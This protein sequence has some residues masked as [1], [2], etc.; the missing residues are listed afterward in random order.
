MTEQ[1]F[2]YMRKLFIHFWMYMY[3]F[4]ESTRHVMAYKRERQKWDEKKL[5]QIY[6]T[7]ILDSPEMPRDND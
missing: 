5:S 7:H 2:Y 1:L 3:F 4:F 6:L